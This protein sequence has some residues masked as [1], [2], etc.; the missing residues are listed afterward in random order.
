MRLLASD[1]YIAYRFDSCCCSRRCVLSAGWERPKGA[2]PL[3][4]ATQALR[5]CLQYHTRMCMK[6]IH[7][8][9]EL[10]RVAMQYESW[11]LWNKLTKAN[12]A[13]S[14]TVRQGDGHAK[15]KKRAQSDTRSVRRNNGRTSASIITLLRTSFSLHIPV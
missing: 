14:G 3:K 9:S 4:H 10:I 7:R 8:N 6:T 15:Q 2:V 13:V 11:V 5:C 12:E 1:R